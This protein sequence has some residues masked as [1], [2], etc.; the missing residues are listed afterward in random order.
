MDQSRTY[1]KALFRLFL[2]MMWTDRVFSL[3]QKKILDLNAGIG[4]P[5]TIGFDLAIARLFPVQF[6]FGLGKV[7]IENMVKKYLNPGDYTQEVSGYT[8]TPQ[9]NLSWTSMTGFI[10]Y[11]FD[12]SFYISAL[13]TTWI[14]GGGVSVVASGGALQNSAIQLGSLNF[15]LYQPM[16]GITLGWRYTLGS[17]PYYFDLSGGILKF[18]E[19]RGAIGLSTIA[20]PFSSLIPEE[21]KKQIEDAKNTIHASFQDF[22]GKYRAKVQYAP[23]LSITVGRWI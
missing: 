13:Y 22:V 5:R 2:L 12:E 4:L 14:I 10:E 18:L 3:D 19:P 16:T 21:N 7:P 6:G 20:D 17:S 15:T 9:L 1:L 23:S 11:F 8:L